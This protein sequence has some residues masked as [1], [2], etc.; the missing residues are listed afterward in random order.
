M[1]LFKKSISSY[2]SDNCICAYILHVVV[3]KSS[4]VDIQQASRYIT[5]L[6]LPALSN[7][8]ISSAPHPSDFQ[9]ALGLP[10][11]C[12]IRFEDS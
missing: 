3:S 4:A 8:S 9:V 6:S 5:E 10:Q 7:R 2:T 1:S 12:P 11:A